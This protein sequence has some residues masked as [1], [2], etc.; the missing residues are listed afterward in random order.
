MVLI[1]RIND[2]CHYAEK[3][4]GLLIASATYIKDA[5]LKSYILL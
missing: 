5:R 2:H 4:E 1:K 3:T